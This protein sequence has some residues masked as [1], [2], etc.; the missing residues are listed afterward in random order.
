LTYQ[1]VQVCAGPVEASHRPQTEQPY[2]PKPQPI[3]S[4]GVYKGGGGVLLKGCLQL[5]YQNVH[6][7]AGFVEANH[8]LQTEGLTP[9]PTTPYLGYI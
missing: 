4:G 3:L 2:P 5:T 9:Y 6:V 1:D 7:R 8:R